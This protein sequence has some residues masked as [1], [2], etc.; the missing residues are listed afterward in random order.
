MV[1]TPTASPAATTAGARRAGRA[2]AAAASPAA[3]TSQASVAKSPWGCTI[4]PIV[5][6]G[7]QTAAMA[8]A[9]VPPPTPSTR[10]PSQPAP[11]SRASEPAIQTATGT[12]L[13]EIPM[14]QATST[15]LVTG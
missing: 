7:A 14:P 8:S 6:G 4:C 12:K 3:A 15:S 5:S 10:R 9:A 11:T 13:C 2:R 1:F